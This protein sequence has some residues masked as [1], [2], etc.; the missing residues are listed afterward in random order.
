MS[1]MRIK[2]LKDNAIVPTKGSEY[3]AGYDLYSTEEEVLFTGDTKLIDT[4]WAMEI[5]Y[6]YFGA[7]FARSGLATK[8]G[9]APANKVGVVDSDYRG[10]VMV[11]LH[12][13]SNEDRTISHGER[14]AQ[15][16]MQVTPTIRLLEVEKFPE[17]GRGIKGFG[18]SGR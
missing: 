12:N 7:I 1:R 14:I 5:P 4:G 13:H 16:V 9:L 8:K 15:M 17:T 2:R 11:A 18:S 6:G 3:A 10:E